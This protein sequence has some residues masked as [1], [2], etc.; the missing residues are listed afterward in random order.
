MLRLKHVSM[1]TLINIGSSILNNWQCRIRV[2]T[3]LKD[4]INEKYPDKSW[5]F[6]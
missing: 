3:L 2:H 5:L 1:I 4:Y 6:G